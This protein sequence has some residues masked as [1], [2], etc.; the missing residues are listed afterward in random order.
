MSSSVGGE[1]FKGGDVQVGRQRTQSII[2]QISFR[3]RLAI[4]NGRLPQ[5]RPHGDQFS[6]SALESEVD[7]R[8][9][10]ATDG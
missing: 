3:E 6:L 9:Q 2:G 4:S 7:T 10:R 5:N 8:R 1:R